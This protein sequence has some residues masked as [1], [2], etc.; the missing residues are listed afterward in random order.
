MRAAPID[1]FFVHD[2]RIRPDGVMVHDMNL[3]QVKAPSESHYA[4][5]YLKRVA[6]IAG[7]TAFGTLA[8]SK[9]PLLMPEGGQ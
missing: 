2:G 6:T 3:F 9:C 1:D 5:D 4:W 7:E 8:Q